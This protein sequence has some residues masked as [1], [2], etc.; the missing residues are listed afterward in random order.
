MITIEDK[1]LLKMA[2][3]IYDA[4]FTG[5]NKYFRANKV[6][7]ILDWLKEGDIEGHT[8]QSLTAQWR[9]YDG[10]EDEE[11]E[12][13]RQSSHPFAVVHHEACQCDLCTYDRRRDE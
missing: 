9:Y 3:D 10:I 6:Q 12:D 13:T 7:E 5:N 11:P 4:C 8:L 2:N 1:S